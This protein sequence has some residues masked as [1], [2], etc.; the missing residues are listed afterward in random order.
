MPRCAHH[1]TSF[2]PTCTLCQAARR[3]NDAI[4]AGHVHLAGQHE[5]DV[6][7]EELKLILD[8]LGH[9]EALVTDLSS[10]SD[11]GRR[12]KRRLYRISRTLGVPVGW[13]DL[14]VDIAARMRAANT[15]P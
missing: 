6:F 8:V 13:D 4:R 11:F 15:A 7:G 5:V 2:E 3:M 12:N 1:P 10:V 9:P 14:L